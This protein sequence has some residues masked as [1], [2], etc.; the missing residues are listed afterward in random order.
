MAVEEEGSVIVVV[1]VASS[2]WLEGDSML[3]ARRIV[4]DCGGA[5]APLLIFGSCHWEVLCVGNEEYLWSSKH[6]TSRR[7]YCAVN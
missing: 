7:R 5:N 1:I 3:C 2:S 4:D 6:V